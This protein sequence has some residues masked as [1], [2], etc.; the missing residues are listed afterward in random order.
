M[1]ALAL[2]LAIVAPA[3]ASDPYVTPDEPALGALHV[4]LDTDF[5]WGIGSQMYLG[6]LAHAEGQLPVWRTGAATGT[7]DFGLRVAY[8][9]EGLY[10][11]PW[12]DRTQFEGANH[13]VATQVVLGTT[14]H[15]TPQRRLGVGVRAL[16]GWN[17]LVRE[18]TLT[19]AA[20]DFTT[21]QSWVRHRVIASGDVTLSYRAS[22]NVGVNLAITAPFPTDSSYVIG[23]VSVGIG[24]SFYL[25]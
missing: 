9:N 6:A 17:A 13:R 25:R 15:V 1:I 8:G 22:R 4:R 18:G 10:F 21:T 19:Y 20:E 24:T 16:I 7:L 3:A 5:S 2:S 11:A 14:F 23:L 12:I